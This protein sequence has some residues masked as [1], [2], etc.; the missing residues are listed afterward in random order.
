M[1]DGSQKLR[2]KV[3]IM[4]DGSQKLRKKVGIVCDEVALSTKK[5]RYDV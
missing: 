1:C 3:G 2:K 5:G 4:C